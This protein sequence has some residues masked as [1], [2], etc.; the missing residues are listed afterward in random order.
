MDVNDEMM[1]ELFMHEEAKPP[2][3]NKAGSWSFPL[4]FVTESI[5]TPFL[6]VIL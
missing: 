2:V 1:T 3:T 4:L 5:S 6:G